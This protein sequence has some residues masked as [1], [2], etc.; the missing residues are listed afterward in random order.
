MRFDEEQH[1]PGM[2]DVKHFLSWLT[3]AED[4]QI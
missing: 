1:S 2:Y 4:E 3:A